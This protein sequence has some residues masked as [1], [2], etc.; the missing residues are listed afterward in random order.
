MKLGSNLSV[1]KCAQEDF[2]SH[3]HTR[4]YVCATTIFLSNSMGNSFIGHALSIKLPLLFSFWAQ[5]VKFN[6]G[7]NSVLTRSILSQ[8]SHLSLIIIS[9]CTYLCHP[10]LQG[11]E[12]LDGRHLTNFFVLWVSRGTGNGF[13]HFGFCP[14][15]QYSPGEVGGGLLLE[16][17]VYHDYGHPNQYP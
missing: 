16:F 14:I 11:W 6:F 10:C 5:R 9:P 7:E 17:I 15:S 8:L 13:P 2:P 3:S 4:K 1:F 12:I